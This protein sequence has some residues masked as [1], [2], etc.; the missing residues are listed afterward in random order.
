MKKILETICRTFKQSPDADL[1][2]AS[3]IAVAYFTDSVIL[4]YFPLAT[5]VKQYIWGH[6]AY[7]QTREYIQRYLDEGEKVNEKAI[8]RVFEPC[9]YFGC[10]YA[11]REFKRKNSL[12]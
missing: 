2:L 8:K 6:M 12:I 11:L 3:T 9:H 1:F 7:L 4:A 10:R 5:A